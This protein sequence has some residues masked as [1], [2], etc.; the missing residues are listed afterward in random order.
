MTGHNYEPGEFTHPMHT[1]PL[2]RICNDPKKSPQHDEAVPWSNLHCIGCG[3]TPE[4]LHEYTPA[5]TG[6]DISPNEYVWR[7]EGTLNRSN[8]HFL[9]TDCY[10]K[11]G[12]PVAP[13]PG[14]TAP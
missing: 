11:Q 13:Y 2:C 14:W 1:D 6:E 3:K 4:E 7:E 5:F 12:M 9:C 10:I 8:G